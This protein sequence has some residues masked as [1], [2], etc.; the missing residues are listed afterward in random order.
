VFSFAIVEHFDVLK[1]VPISF[2]VVGVL[3]AMNPFDLELAEEAL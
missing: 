1:Q 3:G 2:V